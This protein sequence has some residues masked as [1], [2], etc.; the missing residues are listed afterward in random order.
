M[1]E[2]IVS[3]DVDGLPVPRSFKEYVFYKLD[4]NFAI[5]GL[6]ALGGF[7]VYSGNNETVALS[8]GALATYIGSRATK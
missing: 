3:T 6:I 7:G 1:P 5:L 2:P 4:R 8:V